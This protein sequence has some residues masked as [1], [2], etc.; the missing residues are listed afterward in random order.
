MDGY[1][2]KRSIMQARSVGME[3][4]SP[5]V[6]AVKGRLPERRRSYE[7]K[8]PP[9][10]PPKP[11][12]APVETDCSEHTPFATDLD[13]ED[14]TEEHRRTTNSPSSGYD[15]SFAAPISSPSLRPEHQIVEIS[16]D[17]M[18]NRRS[19]TN[20]SSYQKDE[21]YIANRIDRLLAGTGST[22]SANQVIESPSISRTDEVS[23]SCSGAIASYPSAEFSLP[24]Q[25]EGDGPSLQETPVP[26]TRIL[27]TPQINQ[28]CDGGLEGA[29]DL[30][31]IPTSP[32]NADDVSDIKAS[33]P[34]PGGPL[35]ASVTGRIDAQPASRK[36]AVDTTDATLFSSI[37]SAVAVTSVGGKTATFTSES[38]AQPTVPPIRR[39][40]TSTN[41]LLA[42][43]NPSGLSGPAR[44]GIAPQKAPRNARAHTRSAK[45][46][47]SV[48]KESTVKTKKNAGYGQMDPGRINL[49]APQVWDPS[50]VRDWVR[51]WQHG[52][53]DVWYRREAAEL[54]GISTAKNF[55]TSPRAGSASAAADVDVGGR[56]WWRTVPIYLC[57]PPALTAIHSPA[58]SKSATLLS[59]VLKAF[60]NAEDRLAPSLVR[61]VP[62][63]C[64]PSDSIRES[65]AAS[66]QGTLWPC[67]D[68]L[69]RG[70]CGHKHDDDR[71]FVSYR[72]PSCVDMIE[73]CTLFPASL[74]ILGDILR[75]SSVA[76]ACAE[77]TSLGS[78]TL[79]VLGNT[80]RPFFV[81]VFDE[82]SLPW[83]GVSEIADATEAS[84]AIP[85]PMWLHQPKLP[86]PVLELFSGAW[87]TSAPTKENYHTAFCYFP[88]STRTDADW[89][90]SL[91]E[92]SRELPTPNTIACGEWNPAT[93]N[94]GQDNDASLKTNVA[95]FTRQLTAD[96]VAAASGWLSEV[97][98]ARVEISENPENGESQGGS[99]GGDAY[100]Q[101]SPP[102]LF[103]PVLVERA[104]HTRLSTSFRNDSDGEAE[105]RVSDGDGEALEAELIGRRA[106]L[107]KLRQFAMSGEDPNLLFVWGEAGVGC[108]SLLRK[109]CFSLRDNPLWRKSSDNDRV[110]VLCEPPETWYDTGGYRDVAE[111]LEYGE[112]GGGAAQETQGQHK[113]AS[114]EEDVPFLIFPHFVGASHRS[115]SLHGMLLRICSE[116]LV[117]VSPINDPTSIDDL[118]C[119]DTV[120]LAVLLDRLLRELSE[121]VL[122]PSQRAVIVID[123]A[124]A[125]QPHSDAAALWWV[126]CGLPAR[127]RIILG[128]S[129]DM[130]GSLGGTGWSQG[131]KGEVI[132]A[133]LLRRLGRERTGSSFASLH[134]RPLD[135]VSGLLLTTRGLVRFLEE[136]DKNSAFSL[137]TSVTLLS[138]KMS[139]SLNAGLPLYL[140]VV[141]S[142]VGN[143]LRSV[144]PTPSGSQIGS[145]SIAVYAQSHLHAT[146]ADALRCALVGLER[147]IGR[148]VCDPLMSLLLLSDAQADPNNLC[149]ALG[150]FLSKGESPI[151]PTVQLTSEFVARGAY[152]TLVSSLPW[153]LSTSVEG[154]VKF[155]HS[156]FADVVYSRYI[157]VHTRNVYR[158]DAGC[159]TKCTSVLNIAMDAVSPYLCQEC[160]AVHRS[161]AATYVQCHTEL[162]A[163]SGSR[164]RL[165][166]E[167]GEWEQ[168]T[169]LSERS[170]HIVVAAMAHLLLAGDYRGV[171]KFVQSVS[172]TGDAMRTALHMCCSVYLRFGHTN[173]HSARQGQEWVRGRTAAG[174]NPVEPGQENPG[175]SK[176]SLSRAESC[177]SRS[178]LDPSEDAVEEYEAWVVVGLLAV[179]NAGMQDAGCPVPV[180]VAL[181]PLVL[182]RDGVPQSHLDVFTS[183]LVPTRWRS[184]LLRKWVFIFTERDVEGV[185]R[186]VH[187]SIGEA[188]KILATLLEGTKDPQK[189]GG[190]VK[191]TRKYLPPEPEDEYESDSEEDSEVD[192]QKGDVDGYEGET[193]EAGP[194]AVGRDTFMGRSRFWRS[195]HRLGRRA[196]G[197]RAKGDGSLEPTPPAPPHDALLPPPRRRLRR[198][199]CLA[200]SIQGRFLHFLRSLGETD[201][202]AFSENNFQNFVRSG[203]MVSRKKTE[204]EMSMSSQRWAAV[205][206]AIE[207][208]C[209][210]SGNEFALATVTEGLRYARTM[211]FLGRRPG[212]MRMLLQGVVPYLRSCKTFGYVGFQNQVKACEHIRKIRSV[213][214]SSTVVIEKDVFTDA[215]LDPPEVLLLVEM[216]AVVGSPQYIGDVPVIPLLQQRLRGVSFASALLLDFECD[217]LVFVLERVAREQIY[218]E[219]PHSSSASKTV[220]LERIDM[221]GQSYSLHAVQSITRVSLRVPSLSWLKFSMTLPLYAFRQKVMRAI[222]LGPEEMS[223]VEITALSVL[224]TGNRW[225]RELKFAYYAPDVLLARSLE[226]PAEVDEDGN[227]LVRVPPVRPLSSLADTIM[228]STLVQVVF[229]TAA[230]PVGALRG[231][232]ITDLSLSRRGLG[233]A[234][235]VVLAEFLKRNRSLVTLDL[236]QNSIG[237][238]AAFA[239]SA[240]LPFHP[241]L[242]IVNLSTNRIHTNGAIILFDS[243]NFNKGK[244]ESLNVQ[245]NNISSAAAPSLS[246]YVRSNKHLVSLF[247]G[248]NPLGN[249]ALASFSH[250]LKRNTT[251]T[252]LEVSN[253]AMGLEACKELAACMRTHPSLQ[254]LNIE[255]NDLPPRPMSFIISAARQSTA[256]K[257]LNLRHN[258]CGNETGKLLVD[259][260]RDS[261]TLESL[262]VDDNLLGPDVGAEV[263]RTLVKNKTLTELNIEYNDLGPVAG[264]ALAEMLQVNHTITSC[265]FGSN[266]FGP[267]GARAIAETIRTTH[268]LRK[269]SLDYNDFSAVGGKLIVQ[270]ISV[271]LGKSLT[272]LNLAFNNIGPEASSILARF[273]ARGTRLRK[274]DIRGSN[275]GPDAAR[276]L[277]GS[278]PSNPYLEDLDIGSNTIGLP[279]LRDICAALETSSTL[280]VLG[281]SQLNARHDGCSAIAQL[282]RVNRGLRKIDLSANG[283]TLE[284]VKELARC[285]RTNRTLVT[286]DLRENR[287]GPNGA[288]ALAETVRVSPSLVDILLDDDI[289]ESGRKS[290]A[291]AHIVQSLGTEGM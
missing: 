248:N 74:G 103:D 60:R 114:V 213:L 252:E 235:V 279:A 142:H 7:W 32:Q 127:V 79:G 168:G 62:I 164:A 157:S 272:E 116:L 244:I 113:E 136:D 72:M 93:R 224:L 52:E 201:A 140:S 59:G 134:L 280:Q 33:T 75:L 148:H 269:L 229:M 207:Q 35:P 94:K 242:R 204:D 41:P 96:L 251:L 260:L 156:L 124:D 240:S 139:S 245:F 236:S 61:L 254:S 90:A 101:L 180:L 277:A 77:G 214:S 28:L 2:K 238:D 81:G 23:E 203:L 65:A 17:R 69:C 43:S 227:H 71:T 234:D 133:S 8:T 191:T 83:I 231:D 63:M 132:V 129:G 122:R 285:L 253:S 112:E 208:I 200:R 3:L 275:M 206:Q 291:E 209:Q 88:P 5:P 130:I 173:S 210:I 274:L 218:G 246:S 264:K 233:T 216:M 215:D 243:L 187:P 150:A 175:L 46:H 146:L 111:W 55:R 138:R 38:I 217:V 290:L 237:E 196:F 66:T 20:L 184:F 143:A 165:D 135:A 19:L 76:S 109:L 261:A 220:L 68:P 181:V 29:E 230:L 67:K 282:L 289:G 1:G 99:G 212:A 97:D 40:N 250:A 73:G 166:P 273:I 177:V 284:S 6:R 169:A 48:S 24:R 15:R 126:P 283:I 249:D 266:E 22:F 221:G 188:V 4:N 131:V 147:L 47:T 174:I 259:L 16:S 82:G 226:E 199:S 10:T 45:L 167:L 262:T 86:W 222:E 44:P 51:E 110:E 145:L 268:T 189:Y 158:G 128:L 31:R 171:L 100:T 281:L 205:L 85:L 192:D 21:M 54:G 271:A 36:A 102:Q 95:A 161:L 225:L 223:D 152:C 117:L 57:L 256:L 155:S 105:S 106:E 288:L 144:A 257:I 270:A 151:R 194:A 14:D 30:P 9:F 267:V 241:A 92:I 163:S 107:Q 25:R 197:G 108:T 286:L 137:H 120:S 12:I 195:M 87:D 78:S 80:P 172:F 232:I 11:P 141:S 53:H 13:M 219:R 154:S 265:D 190:L 202:W 56:W 179:L 34:T 104:L 276:V 123:D 287:V 247:I 159:P 185:A 198:G 211:R 182:S 98:V 186:F 125:L 89:A 263:A 42:A 178:L 39:P 121:F 258:C 153:L 84:Y 49:E 64:L 183:Q 119:E 118:A 27:E 228:S 160:A 149:R 37:P 278:L 193:N 18:S 91:L 170:R 115:R 70:A 162:C 26:G 50:T 239:L 255:H 176:K 58:I